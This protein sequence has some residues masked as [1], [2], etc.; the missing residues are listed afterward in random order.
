MVR[1]IN[2]CV[3]SVI[4]VALFIPTIKMFTVFS[5]KKIPAEKKELPDE[6]LLHA[7]LALQP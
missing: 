2:L 4:L 5:K 7:L 6:K 1:I 3:S